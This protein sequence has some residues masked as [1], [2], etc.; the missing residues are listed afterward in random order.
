MSRLTSPTGVPISHAVGTQSGQ[1][2]HAHLN[3][4]VLY[5]RERMFAHGGRI[6]HLHAIFLDGDHNFLADRRIGSGD[7]TRLALRMRT[8]FATA[9]QLGSRALIVVHNHPS[10]DCRPSARDIASTRRIA[11]IAAA[12]DIELLDHLIITPDHAYSI[13]AGGTLRW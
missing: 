4:M 11:A 3:A 2:Y 12:L 13:R 1:G 10:G 9:L 5:L 8:L 6:E 7:A